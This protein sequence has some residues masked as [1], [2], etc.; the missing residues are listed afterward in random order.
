MVGPLSHLIPTSQLRRDVRTIETR[1]L[2]VALLDPERTIKGPGSSA[3]VRERVIFCNRRSTVNGAHSI[4]KSLSAK[5]H[6]GA[7][8]RQP[9]QDTQVVLLVGWQFAYRLTVGAINTRCN[10]QVQGR[11]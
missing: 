7:R 11:T 4:H 10:P 2:T 1:S 8:G 6:T 9:I 5:L 3:T